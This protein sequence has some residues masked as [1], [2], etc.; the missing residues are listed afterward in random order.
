[1]TSDFIFYFKMII[2]LQN[3]NHK[4]LINRVP[5]DSGILLLSVGRFTEE[6]KQ[7]QNGKSEADFSKTVRLGGGTIGCDRSSLEAWNKAYYNTMRSYL[8]R[9]LFAGKDQ[10]MMATCCLETDLCLLLNSDLNNW[11]K[12]QDWLIGN[13]PNENYQRLSLI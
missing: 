1:M 4:K 8:K 7:L 12:L 3:F 13:L 5:E 2:Y 11:F 9:N 10:N 6:E